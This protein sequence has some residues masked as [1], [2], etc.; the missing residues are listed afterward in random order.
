MADDGWAGNLSPDAVSGGRT[1]MHAAARVPTLLETHGF[2]FTVMP[3][4]EKLPR[5]CPID[6]VA[7]GIYSPG[8]FHSDVVRPRSTRSFCAA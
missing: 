5:E 4:R 3:V 8:A 2:D 6:C 7:T 1:P